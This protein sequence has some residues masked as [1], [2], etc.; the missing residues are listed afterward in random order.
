MSGRP[1]PRTY[2]PIDPERSA[3]VASTRRSLGTGARSYF[4]DY[5]ARST[6]GASNADTVLHPDHVFGPAVTYLVLMCLSATMFALDYLG[7]GRSAQ[8]ITRYTLMDTTW[9]THTWSGMIGLY[10]AA[11]GASTLMFTFMVILHW[12]AA[13]TD[14]AAKKDSPWNI[15]TPAKVNLVHIVG[16]VSIDAVL[17]FNAGL[18]TGVDEIFQ[19]TAYMVLS[20]VCIL[21]MRVSH[22]TEPWTLIGAFF[23]RAGAIIVCSLN[24]SLTDMIID[25]RMKSAFIIYAVVLLFMDALHVIARI[26]RPLGRTRHP[27]RCGDGP[28][29]FLIDTFSSGTYPKVTP[30][31][32]GA[33]GAYEGRYVFLGSTA[34]AVAHGAGLATFVALVFTGTIESYARL[35]F[36]V[37]GMFVWSRAYP[38]LKWFMPILWGA[39][40]LLYTLQAV[41]GGLKYRWALNGMDKLS[42]PGTSLSI[43]IQDFVIVSL[44]G[45]IYMVTA[46]QEYIFVGCL[47][48]V[49]ALYILNIASQDWYYHVIAALAPLVPF[50]F[51]VIREEH[52]SYDTTDVGLISLMFTL[53]GIRSIVLFLR[54]YAFG[55]VEKTGAE[56][57]WSGSKMGYLA[58]ATVWLPVFQL[59]IAIATS[60]IVMTHT[61]YDTKAAIEAGLPTGITI[62]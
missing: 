16:L 36:N 11:M 26:T 60:V 4:S 22:T 15:F 3:P 28:L 33:H 57:W 47:V 12:H 23:C 13:R 35:D 39:P 31:E 2:D 25:N 59:L 55:Y 8:Y 45:P 44:L 46:W 43:A 34:L 30:P 37:Q 52:I 20:A 9:A 38:L 51:V 6:G 32:V 7:A 10:S 41:W 21:F 50:L 54:T 42:M 24:I 61:Y 49:A 29:Y 62:A 58:M 40:C 5:A 19:I 17:A 18:M 56:R 48:A 14:A 1:S 27:E 53:Y